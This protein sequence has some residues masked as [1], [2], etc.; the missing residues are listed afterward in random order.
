[1]TAIS[2]QVQTI[3]EEG[4][5]HDDCKYRKVT[6]ELQPYGEGNA[7]ERLVECMVDKQTWLCP[8]LW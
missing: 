5:C 2:T 7:E 4:R 1:M 8:A 3:L 6:V